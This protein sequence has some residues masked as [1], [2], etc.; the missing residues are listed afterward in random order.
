MNTEQQGK[1]E[2]SYKEIL[3]FY[4]WVKELI[5][6]SERSDSE[7]RLSGAA[8]NELRSAFDHIARAHGVM[9]GVGV[10]NEKSISEN[11]GIDAFAYCDKNLDKAFAHLYRAG[12]DAYDVI[13][14]EFRD[15]IKAILKE[16]PSDIL[17]R[18]IPDASEEIIQKGDEARELL[19]KAKMEKDVQDRKNEEE[20]YKKYESA[21]ALLKE[22]LNRLQKAEPEMSKLYQEYLMMKKKKWAIPLTKV[23]PRCSISRY[24]RLSENLVRVGKTV[25]N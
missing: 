25:L 15:N 11:N 14:I 22:V 18:V 23:G 3:E 7:Q 4:F 12:Y 24:G 17:Y 19:I 2:K 1:L 5:M 6:S 9:Y 16:L 20:A 10:N 8:I 13:S 21:N